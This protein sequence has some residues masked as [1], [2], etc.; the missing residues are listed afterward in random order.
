M[1][2]PY[3]Y[4]NSGTLINLFDEKDD[5][6]LGDIEANY[7]GLRLRQLIEYPIIGNF[8]FKHL[9]KIHQHIF[10]DIFKWAGKTRV[11]NIEKPEAALGGISVEYCDIVDIEKEIISACKMMT[12]IKW[13]D[14]DDKERAEVFAK[15]IAQIW[16]VHPFREGNTRTIIRFCCDFAQ[17]SGFPINREIF[18]DNSIYVRR[19]LVAA[20]AIF[21]DLG[22]LSK[23]QYLIDIV[24][25]AMRSK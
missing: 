2:D 1:H 17:V 25:D 11:I 14:L 19:A 4:P 3:L 9:C 6:I 7:T 20:S 13:A 5:K 16:K 10:Q 23:P 18:K 21:K 15:S 24:F 8:D 22:D 12:S